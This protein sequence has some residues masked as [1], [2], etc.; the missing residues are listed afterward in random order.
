[1]L[2]RRAKV[3]ISVEPKALVTQEWRGTNVLPA[4][5]DSTPLGFALNMEQVVNRG[6]SNELWRITRYNAPALSSVGTEEVLAV[7]MR[8][9]AFENWYV[10]VE[11]PFAPIAL[12]IEKI[13]QN[14]IL[15]AVLLGTCTY[16][17]L[18]AVWWWLDG[19][20][21]HHLH[22][23]ARE[24]SKLQYKD[25]YL[26]EALSSIMPAPLYATNVQGVIKYANDA[27]ALLLGKDR[28]SLYE[29]NIAETLPSVQSL[30]Y[31]QHDS[32][33][34]KTKA[35]TMFT[36]SWPVEHN[37][38]L[39]FVVTKKALCMP[40]GQIYGIMTL[41]QGTDP[42]AYALAHQKVAQGEATANVSEHT[43]STNTAQQKLKDA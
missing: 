38:A 7:A 39:D 28:Q 27:F 20:L 5:N 6:A 24:I 16:V 9:P 19:R 15:W 3:L 37:K 33:L 21:N 1:M 10:V 40:D 25:R 23:T 35:T 31:A 8:V 43:P 42:N 22:V 2:E 4:S 11:T 26:L 29:R 30:L 41:L 14:T 17:L 36:Y 12:T 32:E 13:L 34:F 18:V